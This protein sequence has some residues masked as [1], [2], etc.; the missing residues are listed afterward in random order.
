M[1][2]LRYDGRMKT[3]PD[4]PEFTRFTHAMKDILKVSKTELQKRI[5]AEKRRPS[6]KKD[7][8]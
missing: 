8:V 5:D 2:R 7:R 6:G 4:T 3:P 1:L